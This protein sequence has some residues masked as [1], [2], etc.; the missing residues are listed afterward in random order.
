MRDRGLAFFLLLSI[1]FESSAEGSVILRP[2]L[3]ITGEYTDNFF[4]TQSDPQEEFTTILSPG[5]VVTQKNRDLALMGRYWGGVTH[6]LLY[7]EENR[8]RQG[9]ALDIDLPFLSRFFRG[10]A[11]HISERAEQAQNRTIS[12]STA[13]EEIMSTAKGRIDT[14]SHLGTIRI[15]SKWAPKWF[16]T[17]TYD[18]ASIH[19]K[20]SLLEDVISHDTSLSGRYEIDPGRSSLTVVYGILNTD[21]ER[22]R[23]TE[24]GRVSITGRQ[25]FDPTSSWHGS[26]GESWVSGGPKKLISQ[27]GF[28]KQVRLTLLGIDYLRSVDAREGVIA[29]AVLRQGLTARMSRPINV[30]SLLTLGLEYERQN[31]LSGPEAK[32]SSQALTAG[33]TT[34]FS[35]A[36]SGSIHY[37]YLDEQ[38]RGLLIE[39]VQRNVVGFTF[40]ASPS[41]WK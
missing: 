29:A 36:F 16:S 4:F 24:A 25:G 8:Y 30:K 2:S 31:A 14:V 11:V 10:V 7:T 33:F 22:A 37:T 9:L 17:L 26:I 34:R 6:N 21:F 3:S 38:G 19:Y 27:I 18:N 15:D 1:A 39:D 13:A 28:S 20:G 5:V 40:Y 41:G 32:L 23:D 12:H 35:S